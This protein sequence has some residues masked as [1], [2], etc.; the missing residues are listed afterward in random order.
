VSPSNTG[1]IPGDFRVAGN[2][3]S[4]W[5]SIGQAYL[6]QGLSFDKQFY[7]MDERVGAGVTLIH[8]QSGGGLR[9]IKALLSAAYH[10]TIAKNNLHGG[11]Q[12]G[13]VGKRFSVD[14]ETFPNQMNWGTGQ[15]DPKFPNKE[16][17][18]NQSLTVIDLNWGIGWDKKVSSKFSPFIS[19]AM[20]HSH[21]PKESFFDSNR[22][23]VKPRSLL[24]A[25]ATIQAGKK[26]SVIPSMLV[27]YTT[28][29]SEFLVG[30]NVE[31][32]LSQGENIFKRKAVYGGL[33]M[34]NN[35]ELKNDAAFLVAG[36][37]YY[38]WNGAISYDV[39]L[40]SLHNATNYKGAIEFSIIYTGI[41]TR[42]T[43]TEIPCD[44]Y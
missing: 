23:S 16:V 3:R 26:T 25:G 43:K 39:N 5:K 7:P 33:F 13:Y 27:A 20:F 42:L 22:K 14:D 18:I 12:F 29:A 19:F 10:K 4:Q 32:T 38:N 36:M 17:G 41:N 9:V 31:Y 28:K 11:L 21:F 30:A 40:S 6:T 24:N 35:I 37:K 44:R 2:Y 8:D 34:R 1:N 15:F